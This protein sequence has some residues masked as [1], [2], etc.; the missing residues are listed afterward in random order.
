MRKNPSIPRAPKRL[1]CHPHQTQREGPHS[2][3]A[4]R[5]QSILMALRSPLVVLVSLQSSRVARLLPYGIF[6]IMA[7]TF[8]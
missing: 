1:T 3:A 6:A 4:V 7:L 8:R 2:N 5:S